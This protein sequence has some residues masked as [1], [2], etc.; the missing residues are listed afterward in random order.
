MATVAFAM[1]DL[2]ATDDAPLKHGDDCRPVVRHAFRPFPPLRLAGE[3]QPQRPP[4][5]LRQLRQRGNAEP[6]GGLLGTQDQSRDGRMTI[7]RP[8]I[9][10]LTTGKDSVP[11]FNLVDRSRYV[12]P[13]SKPDGCCLA[14]QCCRD[15]RTGPTKKPRPRSAGP[16]ESASHA[17]S[18]R[19][20]L[21]RPAEAR[22]VKARHVKAQT[23]Y[24]D[25]LH[26]SLITPK[27]TRSKSVLHHDHQESAAGQHRAASAEG[28]TRRRLLRLGATA[29]GRA[30]LTAASNLH[31]C[32]L[33]AGETP[34][35]AQC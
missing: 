19:N 16:D 23:N 26:G 30:N 32:G 31:S 17:K 20:V 2:G 21:H 15:L 4:S 10:D 18:V 33:T 22:H 34:A 7:A 8:G 11:R 24:Y 29:Q 25:V 13:L 9:S 27:C 14:S 5:H 28:A 3:G 6:I 35:I 12:G 1:P